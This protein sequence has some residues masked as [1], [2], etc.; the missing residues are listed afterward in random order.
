[1]RLPFQNKPDHSRAPVLDAL[2]KFRERGD[3]VY[4]PLGHK[5]GRGVDPRVLEIVG[6]DVFASDVLIMNGLDDRRQSQGV[7]DEAEALMA[8]AVHAEQ[9]FFSTCGSSLSIKSAMMAVAGPGEKILISRNA[10][11]SVVS[12]LILSGHVPVWVHP[13][14]DDDLGLA[15]PPEPDDVR[16]AFQE[17]PEAKAML[18]I[19]PTDWGTAADVAGVAEVCHEFDAALLVDEAWGAHLPFHDGLPPCGMQAGADLAVVSVHKMGM[20]I[21]QSSVFHI[22]GDRL[23][24]SVLSQRSD[25]LSTT[26]PSTLIYATLD[27]WRRQMVEHGEELIDQALERAGRIRAAISRM[28][29]LS[30]MGQEMLGRGKAAAIDPLKIT[31]DVDPLGVTGYQAGESMRANCHVDIGSVDTRRIQPAITHSDDE[32]TE[33]RLLEALEALVASADSIERPPTV[34]IPPPG[35]LELEMAMRPRD[36]FFAA[37]EQVPI[38]QAIGRIG[39]ELISPYPP[40]VPAL[41]PGE[42]ITAEVVD[43]LRSGVEAGMLIP[44]AADAELKTLRV[45]AR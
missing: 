26:S 14:W 29:G 37:A 40:G 23:D 18:L 32:E 12:S 20:A 39:A 43:Y 4:G 13:K 11:K 28:A 30:L 38:D 6:P 2:H 3:I 5:Q 10:H 17:N 35:S 34:E 19:S 33:R 16:R 36:A 1:M 9:A 42:V 24:P 44:D 21:E 31:I 22:Q 7:L 27:G 45:V 25:L 8:D 41:A 15:H